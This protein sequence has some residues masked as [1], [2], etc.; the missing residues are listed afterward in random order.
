MH[1]STYVLRNHLNDSALL[2]WI[3]LHGKAWLQKHPQI[4]SEIYPNE[5]HAI[6][7][8]RIHSSNEDLVPPVSCAQNTSNIF[9]EKILQTCAQHNIPSPKRINYT[10]FQ[11]ASSLI[12]EQCNTYTIVDAVKLEGRIKVHD[13]QVTLRVSPT[14]A[15]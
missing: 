2:D 4:M 13:T 15:R 10:A 3:Q 7:N 6:Y 9:Y 5:R 8:T 12:D 1:L 11:S 14:H